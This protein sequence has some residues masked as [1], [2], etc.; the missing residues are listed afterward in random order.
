MIPTKV[1]RFLERMKA[2]YQ[3]ISHPGQMIED[4]VHLRETNPRKSIAKVIIVRAGR[5]EAMVVLPVAYKL[6]M[7]KLGFALEA[8]DILIESEEESSSHFPDCDRGEFPAL[9]KPYRLSCF[10]DETLLDGAD[11]FFSGGHSDESIR[12]NSDDYWRIAEAEIG[13]FRT[14]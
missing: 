4:A 5:K 12:V 6:D 13:D 10:V 11:V 8:D 3:V 14:R 7:E 2:D 9:G 1:K